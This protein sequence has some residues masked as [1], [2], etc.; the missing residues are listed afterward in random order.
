MVGRLRLFDN[1]SSNESLCCPL[2]AIRE[3]PCAACASV[4][5]CLITPKTSPSTSLLLVNSVCSRPNSVSLSRKAC[6]SCS[7]LSCSACNLD[8]I[9]FN[10]CRRSSRLALNA[11]SLSFCTRFW[12][13]LDDFTCCSRS[14]RVSGSL[15]AQAKPESSSGSSITPTIFFIAPS[16]EREWAMASGRGAVACGQS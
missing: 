2:S 9:S 11:A 7:D 3:P 1:S 14:E 13:A 5:A 8:L 4:A 15:A 10:S 6:P 16:P 12:A